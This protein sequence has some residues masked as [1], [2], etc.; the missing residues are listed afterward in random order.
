MM[1]ALQQATFSSNDAAADFCKYYYPPLLNSSVDICAANTTLDMIS[2]WL[3]PFQDLENVL[4]PSIILALKALLEQSARQIHDWDDQWSDTPG[5]GEGTGRILWYSPGH[6]TQKLTVTTGAIAVISALIFLQIA[7][8]VVLLFYIC[9]H[10]TWTT[11]LDAGAM[12]MLGGGFGQ[13]LRTP[14]DTSEIT[15]THLAQRDG[16]IGLPVEGESTDCGVRPTLGGLR[17]LSKRQ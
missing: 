4:Y 8:L 15:I 1:D 12:F 13:H 14:S 3:Q 7:G 9:T 5:F 2:S 10:P 16:F 6:T 17:P 11:R